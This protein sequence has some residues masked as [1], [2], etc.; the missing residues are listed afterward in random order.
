MWLITAISYL[1]LAEIIIEKQEV[2]RDNYTQVEIYRK[3][4]KTLNS[5]HLSGNVSLVW[6]SFCLRRP[7]F[8][9]L[10]GA[11]KLP[12]IPVMP[13]NRRNS[14][15]KHHPIPACIYFIL[16][17]CKI[18]VS[19]L[20]FR[21]LILC[22]RACTHM[23]DA[24]PLRGQRHQIPLKE[25]QMAVT[26]MTWVLGTKLLSLHPNFFILKTCHRWLFLNGLFI[27]L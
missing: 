15:R 2:D 25:S 6:W 26:R 12:S 4:K 1:L 9:D 20:S 14:Q 19:I 17:T 27:A 3:K 23:P 8:H 5:K 13:T 10:P 24:S 7:P 16:I 18:L 22:V 11:L 21:I